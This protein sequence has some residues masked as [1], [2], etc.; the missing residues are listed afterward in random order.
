MGCGGKLIAE[1][2]KE[3]PKSRHGLRYRAIR[4]TSVWNGCGEINLILLVT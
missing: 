3:N 4:G 2:E 1:K